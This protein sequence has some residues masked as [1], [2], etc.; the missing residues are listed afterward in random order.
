MKRRLLTT[1]LAAALCLLAACGGGEPPEVVESLTPVPSESQT[2]ESPVPSAEPS[3]TL[4]P[5]E[6][7]PPAE[8]ASPVP[9][10]D[11]AGESLEAEV[12]QSP[13]GYT[14]LYPAEQ[15][16]VNA[17]EG[18]ETLQVNGA[19]GTYLS[20]CRLDAPNLNQAVAALQFE[21][22]LD[23]EPAGRLFGSEGY[24]G[25]S[26]TAQGD[27]L[28][29]EYI[30][31]QEQGVIYLLELATYGEGADSLELLLA[32]LDSVTLP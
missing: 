22:A 8:S 13:V 23:S 6:S 19:E 14:V 20:L 25:M 26:M 12:Y 4:P 11:V 15:I 17:W 16:T 29:I 10:L 31:C 32:M 30:L 18:G 5:A 2:A 21:Y 27:G 1:A 3:D 28:Y 9:T 7:E 24:A